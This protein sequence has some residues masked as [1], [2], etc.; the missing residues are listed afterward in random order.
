MIVFTGCQPCGYWENTLRCGGV[1]VI[2]LAIS[3][4]KKANYRIEQVNFPTYA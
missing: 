4:L 3:A 2:M 1:K